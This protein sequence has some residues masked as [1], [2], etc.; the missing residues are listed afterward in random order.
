[1][2]RSMRNYFLYEDDNAVQPEKFIPN[3]VAGIL[4]ENKADHTTF[5]SNKIEAIQGIHMIPILP[6]TTIARKSKFVT[7]EWEAFFSKGRM[8]E[9]DNNWRSILLG[10]YATIAPKEAFEALSSKTFEESWLDGGISL[11]WLLAYSA[12]KLEAAHFLI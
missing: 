7:Q 6:V 12:G 2:A 8:E 1:M 3:K 4:F 9:I 5:F 10:N 11:T